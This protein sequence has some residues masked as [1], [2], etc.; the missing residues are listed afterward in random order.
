MGKTQ[1]DGHH[2][3]LA[4]LFSASAIILA[5]GCGLLVLRALTRLSDGQPAAL[6]VRSL[7]AQLAFSQVALYAVAEHIEGYSPSLGSY[8]CEVFVALLVAI[9]ILCFARF[10]ARCELGAHDASAYLRR[11]FACGHI[12]WLPVHCT[13]AYA[14][15]AS[16]GSAR[17]SRPP[18]RSV[19]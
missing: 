8:L 1:S 2:A 6:R 16:A 4:P 15:S 10:L 12:V 13:P 7:F 19:S 9:G 18:P 14:L 11:T 5:L 17:F 3:Y